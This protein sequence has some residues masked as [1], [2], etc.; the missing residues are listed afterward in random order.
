MKQISKD[1]LHKI[2]NEDKSSLK[3]PY[4]N[5]Q[6]KLVHSPST[7]SSSDQEE[8]HGKGATRKKSIMKECTKSPNVK[9]VDCIKSPFRNSPVKIVDLVTPV[10]VPPRNTE[11][12]KSPLVKLK[13]LDIEHSPVKISSLSEDVVG[14]SEQSMKSLRRITL[15]RIPSSAKVQATTKRGHTDMALEGSESETESKKRMSK[16]TTPRS[17]GIDLDSG[18]LHGQEIVKVTEKNILKSNKVDNEHPSDKYNCDQGTGESLNERSV[19]EVLDSTVEHAQEAQGMSEK[20]QEDSSDDSPTSQVLDKVEVYIDR[21]CDDNYI[22]ILSD[23][24]THEAERGHQH[25]ENGGKL[26]ENLSDNHQNKESLC[27]NISAVAS[28]NLVH[29]VSTPKQGEKGL[30]HSGKKIDNKSNADVVCGSGVNSSNIEAGQSNVKDVSNKSQNVKG[31]NEPVASMEVDS[32]NPN[33]QETQGSENLVSSSNYIDQ[34]DVISN[35][36]DHG[37]NKDNVAQE[38]RV[39]NSGLDIVEIADSC[40]MVDTTEKVDISEMQMSQESVQFIEE[41]KVKEDKQDGDD[42]NYVLLK[43]VTEGENEEKFGEKEHIK[44]TGNEIEDSKSPVENKEDKVK[45]PEENDVETAENVQ[46]VDCQ[47]QEDLIKQSKEVVEDKIGSEVCASSQEKG[48]PGS[49][50]PKE[51]GDN[52]N[53]EDIE[54]KKES[55]EELN[56][57]EMDEQEENVPESSSSSKDQQVDNKL[58]ECE[59]TNSDETAVDDFG[60][61][62]KSLIQQAMDKLKEPIVAVTSVEN[63]AEEDLEASSSISKSGE[64]K[65]SKEEQDYKE[66]TLDKVKKLKNGKDITTKKVQSQHMIKEKSNSIHSKDSSKKSL[67][68]PSEAVIDLTEAK[69]PSDKRCQQS[70][71]ITQVQVKHKPTDLKHQHSHPVNRATVLNRRG[72]ANS[73]IVL[74]DTSGIEG[75]NSSKLMVNS[76][77]AYS[78]SSRSSTSIH[79]KS[80]KSLNPASTSQ[81]DVTIKAVSKP[82]LGTQLPYTSKSKIKNNYADIIKSVT[83]K[84]FSGGPETSN[85]KKQS[86]T[87]GGSPAYVNPMLDFSSIKPSPTSSPKVQVL[88]NIH[89]GSGTSPLIPCATSTPKSQVCRTIGQS[90]SSFP[91]SSSPVLQVMNVSRQ[92]TLD[93]KTSEDKNTLRKRVGDKSKILSKRSGDD[94]VVEPSSTQDLSGEDVVG[95]SGQPPELG[96]VI[97][98]DD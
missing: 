22:E 96:S 60:N 20:V 94:G 29:A 24:E 81:P 26:N 36:V 58:Q 52:N 79:R 30:V 33:S 55:I 8:F 69:S 37:N 77:Q 87:Q 66:K 89:G 18:L 4:K 76:K 27:E 65:K 98:L 97:L 21:A 71:K 39:T 57:A 78:S 3:S 28:S 7:L 51:A 70:K 54:N 5:K 84:V 40:D 95:S 2:L 67:R 63:C 16:D 23:E 15:K 34:E 72:S 50:Y 14:K 48:V 11:S 44:N 90:P 43:G 53:G 38:N 25:V 42:Q 80:G 91:K 10:K 75:T 45:E 49:S 1:V 64:K 17:L 59:V 86:Q 88:R 85:A 93:L 41:I 35:S 32:S 56:K 62:A 83:N 73:P 12:P 92:L 31:E 47:K 6:R 46:S 19:I 61:Y 74:S 82:L 13:K 9:L 68:N